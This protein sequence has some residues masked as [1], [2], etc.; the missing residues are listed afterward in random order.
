MTGKLVTMLKKLTRDSLR[1][2]TRTFRGQRKRATYKLENRQIKKIT[3]HTLRRWKTTMK[4]HRTKDILH[5][6]ELLG[7]KTSRV[8]YSIRLW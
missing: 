2:F 4:Y 3:F 6:K 1:H 5:I 8:L 7:T